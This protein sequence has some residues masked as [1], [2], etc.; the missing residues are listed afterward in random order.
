MS[1]HLVSVIDVGDFGAE[2][3]RVGDLNGDGA[4]DLLLTQSQYGT[5]SITCLTAVDISGQVLW[6]HGTP[7]RDNGH[8]YSDLAVQIYDWDDDGQNE[9]L[10]V[11]QA[12]YAELFPGTGYAVERAKR[13]EG[14]AALIVLDASTGVEKSR[15]PL[16]APAD[17]C[18]LFADLT[19]RGRPSDLV[20]KDRYWNM[21]GLSHEGRELWHWAGSTGHYPVIADLDG[22][23][24]DEV[25]VGFALIDHDGRVLFEKDSEGHHQDAACAVR[26]ADGSWRL[27][28]GNHGLHCLTADG[29][30]LW[31][32]PLAEA[33]HVVPGR[34]RTDSELQCMVIDRGQPV[35]DRLRAPAALHLFDLEGHEL[36]RREQP[37]GAWCTACARL[38]WCGPGCPD[39]ALVY[40]RSPVIRI[41]RGNETLYGYQPTE[42]E[43]IYDGDGRIID[44]FTMQ[45]PDTV[46]PADRNAL[47]YALTADV[48]GDSRDEVIFA[49]GRGVCIYANARPLAIPTLY[50][51]T[52]YT[53]I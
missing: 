46:S 50:N 37:E 12:R 41:P 4:P 52:L 23:G 16:P 43:A 53:G 25:F 34:Y 17:D 2:A 14:E 49:G 40:E 31:H 44:S 18:F 24:C 6:Q 38:N 32:H 5:R 35:G 22:D 39:A 42:P 20:V 28:F 45:Y 26:L 1:T 29:R 27:L 8:T 9:V 33:Q 11:Q 3:L 10:Y 47:Y 7:S 13:Y 48:W 15:L 30:E 19:G 51:E 21:W 36:W